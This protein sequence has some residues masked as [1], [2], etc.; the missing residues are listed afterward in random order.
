MV[1]NHNA[2]APTC[3]AHS[4]HPLRCVAVPC[5]SLQP[6][7]AWARTSAEVGRVAARDL[8]PGWPPGPPASAAR[9]HAASHAS[10]WAGMIGVTVAALLATSSFV[11]GMLSIDWRA[12]HLVLWEQS[13][14]REHVLTALQYYVYT[15]G[16]R[17]ARYTAV[18]LV[19]G[20]L[21]V[22]L[23]GSKIVMGSENNWLFD[24]A[25]LCT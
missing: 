23:L 9:R 5:P 11:L 19:I 8:S 1:A 21:Q 24:G 15:I 22:C 25:S 20:T 14:S 4:T 18:L 12:D 7:G 3:Q 6:H 16:A 17:P 2:V 13:V 10:R